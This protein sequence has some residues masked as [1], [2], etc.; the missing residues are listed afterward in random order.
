VRGTVFVNDRSGANAAE[1]DPA[2]LIATGLP[3]ADVKACAPEDLDAAITR[4]VESG[5]RWVG[6]AGGDGTIRSAAERLVGTSCALLPVPMGTL[7]HFA[8]QLG[9]ETLAD[10]AEAMTGV[11]QPVD[12]GEVN[13][14][15]FVNNA[16]VGLYPLL[17]E[18]RERRMGRLP[19]R[20]ADLAALT[21]ELG[22]GH[23]LTVC[24]DDSPVQTWMVFVGN[25]RYCSGLF[26]ITERARL[27]DGILNVRLVRAEGRLSR[28]RVLLAAIAK[29]LRESPLVE[30]REVT[31]IVM[32]PTPREVSVALDGEVIEL[33]APL[34]FRSRPGALLVRVPSSHETSAPMSD[35]ADEAGQTEPPVA[36][37]AR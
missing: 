3:G 1:D 8:R 19:K 23:R 32:D 10:A 4:E 2:G 34:R 36:S 22:K 14:H 27:T 16:S 13:G 7:N 6:V 12:V 33:R 21:E 9:I 25:N 31:E 24:L 11:S 5:A 28:A 17:V 26:S 35:P 29:R 37:S 30:S 18:G 15:V 20:F